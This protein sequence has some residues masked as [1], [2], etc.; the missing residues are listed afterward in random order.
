ME[1]KFV[2]DNNVGKLARWLRMMG[3]DSLLFR[4]E[5]DGKMINIALAEDRVIL[6]KDT[7]IMRRRVITKGRLK[8][9][10]I[11]SDDTKAQLRQ[12]AENLNLD[13]EFRPFS[14]CLEC[15]Q[16]LLARSKEEVK[17]LVPP[18]VFQ[19]QEQ[20]MECLNCH[21]IYWRGTHWRAMNKA[22]RELKGEIVK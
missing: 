1:I 14:I 12:V 19:T 7:Q 21:R 2:V 9:I 10:F 5:D 8:A 20:Y 13:Y 18:F 16:P 3:Y 11:G 17:S 4:E 6:T 22:L 15:N